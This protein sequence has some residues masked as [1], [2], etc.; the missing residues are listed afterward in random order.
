MKNSHTDIKICWLYN[1][2]VMYC[3][4]LYLYVCI[5]KFRLNGLVIGKSDKYSKLY[6]H[7]VNT[8]MLTMSFSV[9]LFRTL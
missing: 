5:L 1:N 9:S 6:S 3:Y 7:V 8:A 4:M 2:T